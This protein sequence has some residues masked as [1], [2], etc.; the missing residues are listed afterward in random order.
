MVREDVV[1]K[2]LERMIEEYSPDQRTH[3]QIAKMLEA[4]YDNT[5]PDNKVDFILS[6]AEEGYRSHARNR[7]IKK[8]ADDAIEKMKAESDPEKKA[9][10]LIQSLDAAVKIWDSQNDSLQRV[11]VN[12]LTPN[13]NDGI[14]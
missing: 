10:Y 6:E 2:F 11:T 8:E 4:L 14:N 3:D 13:I 12:L 9:K 5:F 7:K 1:Y